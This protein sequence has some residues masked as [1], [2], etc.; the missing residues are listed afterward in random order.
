MS[1]LLG[2]LPSSCSAS[3]QNPPVPGWAGTMQK[4]GEEADLVGLAKESR[5][6]ATAP[7]PHQQGPHT[8]KFHSAQ[9][10]TAPLMGRDRQ[11]QGT[12]H[13]PTPQ[14][15]HVT[16]A[17][18]LSQIWGPVRSGHTASSLQDHGRWTKLLDVDIE[19]KVGM[20]TD[21]CALHKHWHWFS[22]LPQDFEGLCQ[23]LVH[24][25][26]SFC[27]EFV[28]QLLEVLARREAERQQWVAGGRQGTPWDQ[29]V[30]KSNLEKSVP[31]GC[32]SFTATGRAVLQVA[33]PLAVPSCCT[34]A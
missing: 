8:C 13:K 10:P 17:C 9:H 29:G 11:P 16:P 24:S 7:A 25:P 26:D 15:S 14:W 23:S 3:S 20:G 31:L 32:W 34:Y 33:A 12:T 22:Y 27:L 28:H 2:M 5:K 30:W 4:W 6:A 19:G 21:T 1:R 18:C